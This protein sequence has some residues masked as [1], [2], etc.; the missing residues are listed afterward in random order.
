[1]FI[2]FWKLTKKLAINLLQ[3]VFPFLGEGMHVII[4]I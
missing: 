4:V 2:F 3:Q 1:M